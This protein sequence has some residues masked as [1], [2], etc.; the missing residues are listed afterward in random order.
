MGGAV[1]QRLNFTFEPDDVDERMCVIEN[2]PRTIVAGEQFAMQIRVRDAFKNGLSGLEPSICLLPKDPAE[3][4]AIAKVSGTDLGKGNYVMSS[5]IYKSFH[6][7][8]ISIHA[9]GKIIHSAVIEARPPYPRP[10]RPT[11]RALRHSFAFF[12]LFTQPHST[13]WLPGSAVRGQRAAG[14]GAPQGARDQSPFRAP[15]KRLTAGRLSPVARRRLSAR[16]RCGNVPGLG[17][18]SRSPQPL[19]IS[20]NC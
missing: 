18:G 8:G 19:V 10:A 4:T 5:K 7:F 3:A 17:R 12:A 20:L 16:M 14:G 13:L 9:G 11:A 15:K 2:L 1:S 6:H